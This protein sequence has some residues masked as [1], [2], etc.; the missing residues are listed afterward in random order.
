MIDKETIVRIE[1]ISNEMRRRIIEV[2][3]QLGNNASHLGGAL[4]AIE[5]FSSLYHC[6]MNYDIQDPVSDTRD[7]LIFSKGHAVLAY[8]TALE[9]AGFLTKNDLDQ[10]ETNGFF[11]YGHPSRNLPKGIEFSGGSLG[12]GVSYGVGA[13]LA[14]V[15][16][17]SPGR[18]YIIAG[19]G[20]CDEGIVWEAITAAAHFKLGNVTIIIDHN[21]LQLDGFTANVMDLRSLA[22]KFEAF[23][24]NVHEVDGHN[25]EQLCNA[26]QLTDSVKPSVIIAHTVKGKGISFM[27][28]KR[29]WHHAR[30]TAEQYGQAVSELQ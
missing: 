5:I 24:G 28:N 22:A 6:I 20:E 27:E 13:A 25:I 11:L 1:K 19:D 14:L 23:G 16:R 12:L 17:K 8:Y 10:F 3:Y 26:L 29:E 15:R 4:S 7:R 9:S 30:L 2:A 18:V 21:K